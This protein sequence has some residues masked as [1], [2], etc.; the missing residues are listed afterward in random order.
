[1][2]LSATRVR[3]IKPE[4]KLKRYADGNGLYLVVYQSG[5]KNWIHRATVDGRR[6]DIGL[7][8]FPAVSLAKA[9]ERCQANRE[10]VADGLDPV[11][12]RRRAK[13]EAAGVPTLRQATKS[14]YEL[15]KPNL[16]NGKHRAN[17]LQ[18]LERHAF[19]ALGDV[20]VDKISPIDI[21]NTLSPIWTSRPP[22]ARRVRQRIRKVFGYCL[23]REYVSVN[24]A[25]ETIDGG[26]AP[27]PPS[28]NHFRA[29][30][31]QEVAQ[32]L[33][34]IDASTAYESAKLAL[35][36]LTLTAC[37]STEA[38][39]A[40]WGEIDLERAVWSVPASRMK[41]GIAHRIP[42]SSQAVAV[43][44]LAKRLDDGSG[45][46]FPSAQAPGRAMSDMTLTAILRRTGLASRATVHGFR[47]S[48]RVW[49]AE[50]SG[51]SWEASEAALAHRVGNAV[52]QAYARTD[53]LDE[54]RPLME[55]W[56]DYITS[57]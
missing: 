23:A 56:A 14:Y 2:S 12:E 26:L 55:A 47:T 11:A 57:A 22:T 17:W 36:F 1:M 43:L 9:R 52:A 42:L 21:L 54:R 29:L 32:A 28:R 18:V 50:C 37:R 7:G 45:Y 49:A 24:P 35:R 8:S 53:W 5:A 16:K 41:T 15:H 46:V 20:P 4:D 51:A 34:T 10:A 27:Q 38:R 3:S 48:F 33:E 44:K 13:Q 30:P 19:P 40:Q 31:Y 6:T 25:G 39:G